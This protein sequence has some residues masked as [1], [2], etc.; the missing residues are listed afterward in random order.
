MWNRPRVVLVSFG[1]AKDIRITKV[2]W[3]RV[4]ESKW[5]EPALE[6]NCSRDRSLAGRD[7]SHQRVLRV[8]L[9]QPV[10]GREGPVPERDPSEKAR[11]LKQ[12][13]LE[14]FESLTIEQCEKLEKSPNRVFWEIQPNNPVYRKVPDVDKTWG[15]R[16]PTAF[17]TRYT[18]LRHVATL[19]LSS[20]MLLMILSWWEGTITEKSQVDETEFIVHFPGSDGTR[21]RSSSR[22]ARGR[23]SGVPEQID[24]S[25]DSERRE[26]LATL[27]GVVR[28]QADVVQRQQEA[29]MRQEEQ[30]KR[31]QE[32]VD[33]LVAAPAAARRELPGVAAEIFPSGSGDPTPVGS[34]PL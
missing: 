13:H 19:R 28:Q 34:E 12:E 29:A 31:L 14:A 8:C 25:G 4:H 24:A 5:C 23:T 15:L 7:R 22:S 10:P 11:N 17:C 6:Q 32:T 26:Q 27:V 18:D 2:H 20:F 21:R 30:M 1:K 3:K 33:R 9:R 16:H